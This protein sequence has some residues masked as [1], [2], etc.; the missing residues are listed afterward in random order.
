MKIVFSE[1]LLFRGLCLVLLAGLIFTY[2]NHFNNPFHFDDDHTIVNNVWIR[3]LKNIPKFFVDGTTTSS[4]PSNQAYR[5]GLTTLNTIDYAIAKSNP[6]GFKKDN[7]SD[8]GLNPFYFH[9]S[10]FICFILQAILMFLLI[11]KIFDISFD[12]R[13]NKYFALFVV[14]F[15]C[16]HTALAETIN[17]IIARADSFSTLMVLLSMVIYIYYPLK[18]KYLLYLIPYVFGFFVKEPTLMLGPIMFFYIALFEKQTDLTKIFSDKETRLKIFASFKSVLFI[19]FIGFILFGFSKIMTSKTFTPGI[20]PVWNYLITQP[21][22]LVQYFKT[23]ILPTELSADTDWQAFTTVFNIKVLLGLM[24]ITGMTWLAFR[25]SRKA[26]FRPITFG[27]FWFFIALIPTSSFIPLS[28]VLNDHRVYFPYIGLALAFSTA[29][30]YLIILK[31]EKKFISTP[32]RIIIT[33]IFVAG[34]LCSHAYGT[35]Q[36][37]KVWSSYES[38]WYDVTQ[39]SPGNGRGL[40]N[41]GLS[42]MSKGNYLAAKKCF[43]NALKLTPNYSILH[44]NLGVL[45]TAMGNL[46]EAENYYK[47]AIALGFY[48]DQSYFYYGSFL[49]GQKRYDDAKQNLKNCIAINPAYTEARFVL[50]ALYNETEDWGALSKLAQE[51]MQYLPG[52]PR[53]LAYLDAAKNKKTKLDV[54]VETAKKNPTADNYINLSLQYY[55]A[56]MYKE[57]ITACEEALKIKPNYAIAYNNICSS[58]NALKMYDKAIEACN[59]ALAINPNFEL[60]KGNL[61]SAKSQLK[62]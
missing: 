58:Y 46:T 25:L 9:L 20:T 28:E 35:H 52:D 17:Y 48:Q 4:L 3:S 32:W 1:K 26:A 23:F 50:M 6:L 59:K 21:F 54:G 19:L 53:C 38:L 12:H 31:D 44:I 33:G 8:V 40:M 47:K 57:C 11:K 27:I 30:I 34:L 37:N 36:R 16:F 55:E 45:S 10:I 13:W 56:G 14:S 2:S 15:Y 29:L 24:F 62:K 49:S 43:E 51:T 61:N 18:R 5:P 60:A 7:I 22:V 41:Y 39:K 42:Q